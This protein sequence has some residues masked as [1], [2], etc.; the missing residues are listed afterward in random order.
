MIILGLESS[1]DDTAAALLTERKILSSIVAS[2][3]DTHHPYGGVVPELA[4]REHTENICFVVERTLCEAGIDFPEIDA[5]AV[6]QGPGLVGA[7]LVGLCYAKG[8]AFSLEVPLVGVNHL[9]GHMASIFFDHPQ[10][11]YPALSLVVS[12][13]HTSLF[14]MQSES[15]FE[16]IARTLDDAAGEALDK[17][18]K[19][20]GLGYPGGPVLDHLAVEGNPEAI[21]FSLPK[22]S[23]G[24]L[25]FSFSGLKS[26]AAR[27]FLEAGWRPLPS[28]S[29]VDVSAIP[30]EI[31]DF[32]AS[33]Q[34]AVVDQILDRLKKALE[35]RDVASI[36]I[37]GGVAC[38]SELRC[39][40]Q[41]LFKEMGVPVYFPN[42]SLTTDNAA[43]IALAGARRIETSQKDSWDLKV[44]PNLPLYR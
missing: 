4:S 40:S 19:L 22:I 42:T 15:K 38:N 30:E 44:N 37:S 35:G 10:A 3:E 28:N 24:E 26:A 1:C 43:M 13:G 31:L 34:K 41:K 21:R 20:L 27:V 8:L 39:R 33:Y 23:S 2:Q 5:I 16:E 6:T 9:Q 14:Y 32:I 25:A 11:E 29:G 18:A 17:M 7:L 36:H 12:G